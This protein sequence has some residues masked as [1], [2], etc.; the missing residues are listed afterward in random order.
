MTP[1]P[2]DPVYRLTQSA[3]IYL[4]GAAL[5]CAVG[6]LLAALN[7]FWAAAAVVVGAAGYAIVRLR[8]RTVITL[9]RRRL[10]VTTVLGES[11]L[12]LADVRDVRLDK[13]LWSRN[14]VVEGKDGQRLKVRDVQDAA[15][16][17]AVIQ[18]LVRHAQDAAV[19]APR[20]PP[21]GADLP[22]LGANLP[23]P[24]ALPTF[25][26]PGTAAERAALDAKLDHKAHVKAFDLG[27]L[28]ERR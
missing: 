9:T 14:L 15:G 12:R 26:T 23:R 22:I 4:L 2:T 20:S 11:S 18:S 6:L 19:L 24:Q 13:D 1:E 3:S 25:L 10:F 7:L 28:E 8:G 16:A 27:F 21:W 17:V 5:G